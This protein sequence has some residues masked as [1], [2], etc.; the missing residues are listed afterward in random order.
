[1]IYMATRPVQLWN[2]V[3]VAVV[4]CYSCLYTIDTYFSNNREWQSRRQ[5]QR[6]IS[7][8]D[9]Q[10]H[11]YLF[12]KTF[13]NNWS[14][15]PLIGD[16]SSDRT[17]A[18][19]TFE[20]FPRWKG[21]IGLNELHR[22]IVLSMSGQLRFDRVHRIY[23]VSDDGIMY[24]VNIPRPQTADQAPYRRA[25]TMEAFALDVLEHVKKIRND[26]KEKYQYLNA[27]LREGGFAYIANFADSKFCADQHPFVNENLVPLLNMNDTIVPVFTLSSPT[28]CRRAF[29]TPTYETIDQSEFDWVTLIP[30]YRSKYKRSE[31]YRKAVWRGA[32]TGHHFP[33]RNT[34]IQLCISATERPDILDAKIV[35]RRI[36]WNTIDKNGTVNGLN[37]STPNDQTNEPF[38][39]SQFLGDKIPMDDF[40]KYRAI[41]DVDGHSWSSRFGQLLCYSSI[42]L[43]VQPNDVD[44]FHPQ[45]QPW[46]HYLPIHSNLSNLYDMVTFAISDDPKIVQIIQNA[47]DW[48]LQHLN[49]PSLI[50]DMAHIWDRYA[51]HLLLQYGNETTG[52][53]SSLLRPLDAIESSPSYGIDWR[54]RRRELFLNFN[55]TPI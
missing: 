37:T 25:K 15:Y 47:N 3:V 39:E 19:Q 6:I 42:I 27:I 8:E 17:N 55:F 21:S 52:E 7:N 13:G 10:S 4:S 36:Q 14:Q 18:L 30:Y 23:I 2:I 43:K 53:T 33:Y 22:A 24:H 45:L 29:P 49:R 11:F 34:R 26:D 40:Q 20:A 48:C 38:D 54:H 46:V 44:Y 12:R 16:E 31:Q 5:Q 41:I 9:S 51:Y 1:M 35:K 32:P 50:R 28:H